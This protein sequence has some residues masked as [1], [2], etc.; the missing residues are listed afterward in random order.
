MTQ[1]LCEA[2]GRPVADQA[3]VCSRC[4]EVVAADL[5]RIIDLAPEVETTVA[6]LTK[7]G[8]QLT[9]GS[10]ERPLPFDAK[11][12]E[13]AE[14][15]KQ[16]LAR[17]ARNVSLERGVPIP[18]SRGELGAVVAARFL[19]AHLEWIRH[20]QEAAAVF[21]DLRE[22]ARELERLVGRPTGLRYR[23]PC[24]AD[25]GDVDEV[26]DPLQCQEIL[27][28]R[29]GA[30]VVKCRFCGA[31]YNAEGRRQWL[32]DEA[33]TTLAHAALI[34]S[35]LTALDVPIAVGTIYSWASRGRLV[36]HGTDQLGRPLYRVGDA[37]DLLSVP[38][39]RVA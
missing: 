4:T 1:P 34:A 5:A 14:A 13:R 25:L 11:A 32:L 17:R 9:A 31:E 37:I 19:G 27:Y 22:A 33:R 39:R 18:H 23:G 36:D 35:A 2:C 8:G 28:A 12:A 21:A 26:G 10:G 24:W 3:Y 20:R 38:R 30:E 15:L 7:F 16:T 6:K 29:P